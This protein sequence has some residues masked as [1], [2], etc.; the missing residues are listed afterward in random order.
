MLLCIECLFNL[1]LQSGLHMLYGGI[2]ANVSSCN[3]ADQ[4][5]VQYQC[6]KIRQGRLRD[7]VTLY[8]DSC[9][10][11]PLDYSE[12]DSATCSGRIFRPLGCLISEAHGI[13]YKFL[14]VDDVL[15]AI[16]S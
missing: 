11:T 16:T 15:S 12:R 10:M 5:G 2:L 7:T 14:R 8:A 3:L 6:F 13:A 9:W 4:T 1:C